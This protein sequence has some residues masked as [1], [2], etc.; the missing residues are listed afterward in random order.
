MHVQNLNNCAQRRDE[1]SEVLLWMPIP[2]TCNT[3]CCLLCESVEDLKSPLPFVSGLSSLPRS[4]PLN[5]SRSASRFA[6]MAPTLPCATSP[7]TPRSC[8]T[9]S[10]RG[11]PS[12]PSPSPSSPSAATPRPWTP[13]ARRT[14][15]QTAPLTRR[16]CWAWTGWSSSRAASPA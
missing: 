1:P 2:S 14:S 4:A 8:T 6:S 10:S 7:P 15:Y 11:T 5:T 3:P 13:S 12:A 9:P 16:R